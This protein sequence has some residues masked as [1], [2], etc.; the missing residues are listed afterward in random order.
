MSSLPTE[1]H[2]F[3][4]EAFVLRHYDYSDHDRIVVLFTREFGLLRAI[5][6][7]LRRP[8]S[9][10]AGRLELLRCNQ[11]LL[12]RGRSLHRIEQCDTVRHF[13]GVYQDYDRLMVALAVGDLVSTFCQ[14]MDPHPELYQAL[15]IFMAHLGEENEPLIALLTFELYFLGVMGYAQDFSY[16]QNCGHPFGSEDRHVFHLHH[17]SLL[18]SDCNPGTLVQHMPRAVGQILSWIQAEEELPREHPN[19][20]K[21]LARA[22]FALRSFFEHIAEKEIKALHF[23]IP[24]TAATR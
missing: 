11:F 14:E 24:A 13:P 8:N 4:V 3:A 19:L 17:G 2:P 15:S 10:M 21:A 1:K 22:H 20:P 6:K 9:K 12:K 23:V 7:G 5:A 18:C 16:C